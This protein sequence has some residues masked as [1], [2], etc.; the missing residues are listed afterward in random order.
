MPDGLLALVA[1][2]ALLVCG[3]AAYQVWTLWTR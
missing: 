3:N 1:V 2:L